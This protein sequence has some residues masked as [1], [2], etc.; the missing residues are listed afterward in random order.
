VSTQLD[1]PCSVLSRSP[2]LLL[3]IFLSTQ[4]L[5]TQPLQL[6]SILHTLLPHCTQ[7]SF[8]SP[9]TDSSLSF[10][11]SLVSRSQSS[12]Q[13]PSSSSTS[14]RTPP[15]PNR[16]LRSPVSPT[17][18]RPFYTSPTSGAHALPSPRDSAA[19][20]RRKTV[21]ASVVAA[22][23][24]QVLAK[25][26]GG[27]LMRGLGIVDSGEGGYEEEYFSPTGGGGRGSTRE[28]GSANGSGGELGLRSPPPRRSTADEVLSGE[29]D[30]PP[31]TFGLKKKKSRQEVTSSSY[32]PSSSIPPPLPASSSSSSSKSHPQY[33]TSNSNSNSNRPAS[34]SSSLP[35]PPLP[36]PP[37]FPRSDS[38][39]LDPR[40]VAGKLDP[41][42]PAL[43]LPSSPRSITNNTRRNRSPSPAP[44]GGEEAS[45][46]ELEPV[47]HAG[48]GSRHLFSPTSSS[49]P[50]GTFPPHPSDPNSSSRQSSGD[51]RPASSSSPPQPPPLVNRLSSSGSRGSSRALPQPPPPNTSTSNPT[52]PSSPPHAAPPPPPPPP[53]TQ[54]QPQHTQSGFQP[55]TT[56][57]K[58]FQQAQRESLRMPIP[59]QERRDPLA[60]YI[61][62]LA[63]ELGPYPSPRRSM[64][65][66]SG[67]VETGQRQSK[68]GG[69]G[70]NVGGGGGGPGGQGG[71]PQRLSMAVP[72]QEEVCLE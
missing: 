3:P 17:S 57:Q 35:V 14:T 22:S 29:M 6:I 60:A 37:Q 26:E 63:N 1:G 51:N 41:P 44:Y 28:S 8:H 33:L 24:Q 62:G 10:T 34:P 20:S 36:V 45:P 65:P 69:A 32:S 49:F 47:N 43:P 72:R 64:D 27:Q 4:L 54:S 38:G 53:I 59:V 46:E 55:P 56:Q 58:Q 61:P 30:S 23:N 2:P 71:G 48:V 12:Q 31:G 16:P 15:S 50:A 5:Q 40:S 19:V 67:G 11:S 13:P 9:R 39:I 18:P 52:L 25:G 68:V 21:G 70:I 7:F 66:G 42:S